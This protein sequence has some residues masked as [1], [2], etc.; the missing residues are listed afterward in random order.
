MEIEREILALERKT[1][2]GWLAGNPDPALTLSG[3]GITYFHAVTNGRLDGLAAVRKLYE[4]YRGAPLFDSYEIVDPKVQV[5]GETVVLTYIL[6]RHN[7]GA[8]GRWNAT[9]I[10]QRTPQGWRVIHTHFSMTNPPLPG[11]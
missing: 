2:E 8:T 5:S 6:A 4:T 10:Y 3:E 11:P 7:R 9:Q 1:M